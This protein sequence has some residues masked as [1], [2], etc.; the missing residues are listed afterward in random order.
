MNEALPSVTRNERTLQSLALDG[1]RESA[2]CAVI[3]LALVATVFAWPANS[4]L[5]H[6]L[7]RGFG[8][9]F[10][11]KSRCSARPSSAKRTKIPSSE[12]PYRNAPQHDAQV[13]SIAS[14][15]S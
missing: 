14:L 8:S 9:C 1:L 6:V 11:R 2:R 15:L 3:S 12:P 7:A 10:R 13:L 4:K 5:T